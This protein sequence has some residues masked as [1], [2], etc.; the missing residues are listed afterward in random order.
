MRG[1]LKAG[2]AWA[3]GGGALLLSVAVPGASWA[4]R[5]YHFSGRVTG[6]RGDTISVSHGVETLE[7][8]R[9]T[10]KLLH[11][12]IGE[13]ITIR[14]RLEA[15]SA[16]PVQPARQQPGRAAPTEYPSSPPLEKKHILLDDRAFYDARTE[17][18]ARD[19]LL[20]VA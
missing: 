5:S 18:P 15:E 19:P 6:V 12:K 13:R 20:E 2:V 3:V 14:Y 11:L 17:A 9:E 1:R 8:R 4:A 7:F 10:P 16:E